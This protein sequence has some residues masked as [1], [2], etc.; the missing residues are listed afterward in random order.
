MGKK[1]TPA[2]SVDESRYICMCA[3]TAPDISTHQEHLAHSAN[4]YNTKSDIALV[5]V[6]HKPK[7]LT[8]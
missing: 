3:C 2:A 1:R 4:E 7:N 5:D 8:N 6:F